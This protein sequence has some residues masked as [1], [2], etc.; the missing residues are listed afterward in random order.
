VAGHTNRGVLNGIRVIECGTFITAPMTA[1]ILADLG[2]EVIKVERPGTGDPFRGF[3]G[4]LYSPQFIAFNRN[5]KSMS[6]DM[7]KPDGQRIVKD[8]VAKCDVLLE[9]FRPGTMDKLGLGGSQLSQLNPRLI[10]C[11]ITGF[12]SDGPYRD[13]PAF[14]T[15][16]QSLSGFLSLYV[17]GAAPQ[18]RGPAVAD[19]IT[20]LYA[21]IAI[22]GAV[23]RREKTGGGA[24]VEVP[25]VEAMTA[26]SNDAFAAYFRKG[27]IQQPTTRAAG[28]Q[29]YAFACAD[30]KSIGI[31]LSSPEKFW[32][33]LAAA[34]ERQDLV[35]DAR[36]RTR[37]GR[38]TNYPALVAELRRTFAARP[39]SDW[40]A[41]L[42]AQDVPYAP[43]YSAGEVADDPQIRHLGSFQKVTHPT[44]GELISAMTPFHFDGQAREIF[45]APPMLGEHNDELLRWIGRS[46]NEIAV[47][48]AGKVI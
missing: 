48:R 36:F 21:A 26:F 27:E 7:S 14:D 28:S 29:A 45:A 1:M 11:S 17:D 31:H 13:R 47:L 15:V 4:K 20:G 30:E 22:E 42:E 39:R 46:D 44:E 34:T 24:V 41:R 40:V 2:A 12:G 3:E 25:M 10:Y 19:A 37:E 38:V 16:A 8:L 23:Y 43:I 6:V 9:N 33:G 18:I 35:T 32:E 5:K